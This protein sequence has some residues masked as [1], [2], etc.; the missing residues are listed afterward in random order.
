M[1]ARSITPGL[2][3]VGALAA[4]AHADPP[5]ANAWTGQLEAGAEVDSNV[6]RVEVG[7]ASKGAPQAAA[8]GRLGTRV[9]GAGRTGWGAWILGGGAQL[10]AI[11]AP[12]VAGESVA[13]LALQARWEVG[14]PHRTAKAFARVEGYDVVA[15]GPSEGARTFATRAGELGLVARDGDR[16][17]TVA[18]GA[19]DFTYKPDADFDWRGPSIALRLDAPIWHRGEDATLEL[20]AEYRLE[21]R[22][23]HGLAFADV[24]APDD[25]P[26]PECSVPTTSTRDDLHHQARIALT[27]TGERVWSLGYELAVDDSTSY[28]QSV[29]RHRALASVTARLPW[30]LVASASAILEIDHYPAPLLVSRDVAS[31]AFSSIDDDNRSTISLLVSRSIGGRWSL[32]AR[33]QYWTDALASDGYEF[34]RQLAYGGLVWGQVR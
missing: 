6:S 5:D 3:I 26:T 2:A 24:C 16:R 11:A 34:R 25:A 23:F 33:Y 27:Y 9:T 15:L 7:P 22:R 29:A 32:E 30:K 4:R 20:A 18:V 8:L 13:A 21:R 14:V 10:R 12:G 17:V 19:R 28:G 1:R 31:Q